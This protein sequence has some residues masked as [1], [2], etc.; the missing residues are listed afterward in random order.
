MLRRGLSDLGCE[1]RGEGH[2]VPW[3]IGDDAEVDRI[4]H[5]LEEEGVFASAVRFPAVAKGEAI[6]RFMLMASHTDEHIERT[7]EACANALRG[8]SWKL[9]NRPLE[10]PQEAQSL[11]A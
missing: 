9:P 8:M 3:F 7:L 6:V 4:S 1:V 11:Y 10:V 5:T 2:I